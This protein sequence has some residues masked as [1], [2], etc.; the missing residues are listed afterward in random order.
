MTP[1]WRLSVLT[2][3]G[4]LL[5]ALGVSTALGYGLWVKLAGYPVAQLEVASGTTMPLMGLN[6][7]IVE[8]GGVRTRIGP[9]GLTVAMTPLEVRLGYREPP[10]PA[11]LHY[12]LLVTSR[13]GVTIHEQSGTFG[14]WFRGLPGSP[15]VRLGRFAVRENG[16]YYVDFTLRPNVRGDSTPPLVP[17]NARLQVRA[18]TP[19]FQLWY[20]VACLL[21]VG[22]GIWLILRGPRAG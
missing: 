10:S 11:S 6:V 19:E 16:S 8:D 5:V 22:L 21:T 14:T 4:T 7:S 18:A 2:A 12:H 17:P 1:L 20:G 9:V 3:V 15:A 13:E